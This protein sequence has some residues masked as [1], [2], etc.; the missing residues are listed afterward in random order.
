MIPIAAPMTI[1]RIS[2]HRLATPK[3]PIASSQESN[4]QKPSGHQNPALF[5]PLRRIENACRRAS[6][7]MVTASDLPPKDI[8]LVLREIHEIE[9]ALKAFKIAV[10]AGEMT[11]Y[12]EGGMRTHDC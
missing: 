12:N 3:P 4:R 9:D 1:A 10:E 5:E 11:G 8:E 2:A 7:I 6:G